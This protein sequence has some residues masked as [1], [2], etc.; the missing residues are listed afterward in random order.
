[1]EWMAWTAPTAGFFV[2]IV[3]LLA[4]YTVWGIRS[5]S[6]P[7]RGLL[8][9]ATTRGDRLFVGLMGSAFIH[10]A[11]VGLTDASVSTALVLSLLFM[12]FIARW[13]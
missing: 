6:L 1:M 9:M 5:P 13:G 8:P 7:R 3:L 12:L 2:V 11:W 10:L 4:A